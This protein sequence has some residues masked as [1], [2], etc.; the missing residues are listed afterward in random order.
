[1]KIKKGP[2]IK[3]VYTH[4]MFNVIRQRTRSE[5]LKGIILVV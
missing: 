2:V 3:L 5:K 4:W 1:M